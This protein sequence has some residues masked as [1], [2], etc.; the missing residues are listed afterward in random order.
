M[1]PGQNMSGIF[2][3]DRIAIEPRLFDSWPGKSGLILEVPT[4]N[5]LSSFYL[6]I[7]RT[8]KFQ[9]KKWE[10]I[11]PSSVFFALL[12]PCVDW[13]AL[14]TQWEP[15]SSLDL[16]T[17]RPLSS[18]WDGTWAQLEVSPHSPSCITGERDWGADVTDRVASPPACFCKTPAN[19]V[20]RPLSMS[21]LPTSSFQ[22]VQISLL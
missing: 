4:L 18:S 11:P 8:Q 3:Q 15:S 20:S 22:S 5:C 13:M 2:S 10:T 1:S 6:L 19:S 9:P 7:R 12:G 16:L 21:Y 14:C 17:Q